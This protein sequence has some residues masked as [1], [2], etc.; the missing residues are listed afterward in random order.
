MSGVQTLVVKSDQE[1]SIVDV[2]NSLMRELR[3]VEGLTVM[4]EESPI[5]ASAANA[6]IERSV[7]EMQSTTRALV[8]D[9]EW[10]HGT[11]FEP[12]SAFFTWAVEFSGQVVSRFQRSVSD[13]KTAYERQKLKSCRKALVPFGELVMFM[14]MEKP[15]DKGE[16]R[17]CVGIMLGLVDRSD[18]VV[19]G[20]TERMVKARMAHRMPVGQRGDA[21]DAKSIRGVPLQPNRAERQLRASRWAWLKLVLSVFRWLQSRTDRQFQS[22]S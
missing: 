5:G 16:V 18:E 6:V 3:G 19:I 21:A 15:K 2:K 22:W 20:T 9:A 11:V 13:G 1:A 8:A 4:P 12:G 14:P 7:W 10:V 17:N